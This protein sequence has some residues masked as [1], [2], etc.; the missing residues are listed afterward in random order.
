MPHLIDYLRE[1]LPRLSYVGVSPNNQDLF[2]PAPAVQQFNPLGFVQASPRRLTPGEENKIFQDSL[3]ASEA[4][5]A[6]EMK[7]QKDEGDALHRYIVRTSSHTSWVESVMGS[8]GVLDPEN[9]QNPAQ[10]A[11]YQRFQ[12]RAER[13]RQRSGTSW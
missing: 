8:S 7:R 9:Y 4:A 13:E 5:W 1:F 11:D 3:R 10:I 12:A 6:A 2:P